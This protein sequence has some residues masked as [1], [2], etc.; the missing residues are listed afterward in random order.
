MQLTYKNGCYE[1][2]YEKHPLW[3]N[4]IK[5]NKFVIPIFALKCSEMTE[6]NVPDDGGDT[7]TMVDVGEFI[8]PIFLKSPSE[9]KRIFDSVPNFKFRDDDVMLCTFAKTGTYNL[10]VQ[11]QMSSNSTQFTDSPKW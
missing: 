8:Q 7:M 11:S 10:Y 2:H 6:V 9:I 5:Q 3:H 1:T 4:S